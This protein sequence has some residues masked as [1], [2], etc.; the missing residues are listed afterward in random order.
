MCTTVEK[1]KDF[2]FY[3]NHDQY[4]KEV[5]LMRKRIEKILH[6]VEETKHVLK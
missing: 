2:C 3:F 4:D 5:L 1:P 6:K